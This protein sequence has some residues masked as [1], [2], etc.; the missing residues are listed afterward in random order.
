MITVHSHWL[1]HMQ[2]MGI[3]ADEPTCKKYGEQEETA[4]NFLF[5]CEALA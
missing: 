1:R 5:D 3:F 2:M 4:E